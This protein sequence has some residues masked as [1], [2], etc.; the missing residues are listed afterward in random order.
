MRGKWLSVVVLVVM[1]G[2]VFSPPDAQA[3]AADNVGK[4]ISDLYLGVM[5]KVVSFMKNRPDPKELATQLT[6]LKDET[7]KQMVDLGKKREAL[8]TTGKKGVDDSIMQTM[9]K[10]DPNMFTEFLDGKNHY[11]K[12]DPNLGKLIMDF[13]MI[14]QYAVFDNLKQHA[15]EEAKRLGIK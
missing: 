8:D 15:P 4:A 5:Q 11:G 3:Q 13:H 7:I 1:M 2:A 6:Q 12:L 9:N 14:P 10:L